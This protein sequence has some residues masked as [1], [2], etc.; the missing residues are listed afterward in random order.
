MILRLSKHRN[1]VLVWLC[2]TCV[3]LGLTTGAFAQSLPDDETEAWT[4]VL[5]Q[6]T[7][8]MLSSFLNK[9]PATGKLNLILEMYQTAE[10]GAPVEESVQVETETAAEETTVA[11]PTLKA[12]VNIEFEGNMLELREGKLFNRISGQELSLLELLETAPQFAPPIEGIPEEMWK[13][14][15][16]YACHKW[17]QERLCE[18]GERLSGMSETALTRIEHPFGGEFKRFL[19]ERAAS[20]C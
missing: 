13:S 18:H 16:C 5:N 1:S 10:D 20:G 11:E 12:S 19:I 15:T 4:V 8:T 17:S 14:G 2:L 3:S 9:F 6:P 7:K